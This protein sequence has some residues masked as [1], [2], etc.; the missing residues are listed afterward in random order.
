[1]T[2][3]TRASTLGAAIAAVAALLYA[4]SCERPVPS[5]AGPSP[6]VQLPE[7]KE[8]ELRTPQAFEVYANPAER[9]RALFTE[10]SRVMLHPR[11]ANCHPNGDTPLQYAGR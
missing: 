6:A 7:A 5:A 1:M 10:A 8:G 2:R 3:S 9:S 11:C 4:S